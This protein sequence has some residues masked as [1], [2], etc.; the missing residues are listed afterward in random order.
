MKCCIVAYNNM[1]CAACCAK[2]ETGVTYCTLCAATTLTAP[3]NDLEA[4]RALFEANKGEIAGVILEPVVGNSGFIAPTQDFL[5][6]RS[7]R[8]HPLQVKI[9]SGTSC[10]KEGC[11]PGKRPEKRTKVDLFSGTNG[12]VLVWSR[13]LSSSPPSA[14]SASSRPRRTSCRSAPAARISH[15]TGTGHTEG[16]RVEMYRAVGSSFRVLLCGRRHAQRAAYGVREQCCRGLHRVSGGA[17]GLRDVCTED[18]ALLCFDEVMTGFRIAKGCAQ[19]HFGIMPDL[20]TVR[21]PLALKL[22]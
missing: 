18:G 5:Q 21:S 7:R 17:Q 13:A 20:T 2:I 14:T 1:Y 10:R 16:G 4:V 15:G 12:G 22:R 9:C 11:V 3:Y 8:A 6:A 19:A